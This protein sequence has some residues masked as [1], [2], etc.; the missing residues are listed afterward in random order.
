MGNLRQITRDG[1]QLLGAEFRTAGRPITRTLDLGGGRQI[2]RSYDYDQGGRLNH[3]DVKVGDRTFA[4]STLSFEGL[5]RIKAQQLGVS[6]GKRSNVW[7]Y[8]DR[9][10]VRGMIALTND[11]NA[12]ARSSAARWPPIRGK[13]SRQ[14]S[15]LAEPRIS[16]SRARRARKS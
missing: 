15:K 16:T 3:L 6:N 4:G 11:P 2:I 13:L 7:S 5:Q 14:L 10:R 9:G 8:D 12:A 1:T